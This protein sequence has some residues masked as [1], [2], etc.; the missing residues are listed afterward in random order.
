MSFP[1]HIT[2][3]KD[4]DK[5]VIKLILDEASEYKETVS[6]KNQNV[7]EILSGRSVI[8]LFFENSTRTRVSFELAEKL[9]GMKAVNFT[10]GISSL[11]KGESDV[12]TIRNL[13]AMKFDCVVVRHSEN[14]FYQKV[15]DNSSACVINGGDGTNEHPT[16]G[17]LDM[18]TLREIFGK[19][20]GI[21]VCI[22]G[23][24]SHSR[25]ARSD[26]YGLNK[27]G[28]NVSICAPGAYI[29]GDA[30][31][32]GVTIIDSIDDAIKNT[33]ALVLLRI[34]QERGAGEQITNEEFHDKYGMNEKRLTLNPDI[35]ILHP[36]PWNTGVELD[37]YVVDSENFYGYKQVTNGLAVRLA[38]LKLLLLR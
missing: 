4:L 5:D 3:L 8:N 24:I 2:G 34:Q 32:L 29:P 12:D 13:D 27:F 10:S 25:V 19:L 16:Q 36:G 11:S 14:G 37:Q 9:L 23:N 15:V 35:K 6:D 30:D 21:K 22:V 28:A 33:D 7:K 17:L 1:K 38:I 20:E 31:D 26:I 18:L